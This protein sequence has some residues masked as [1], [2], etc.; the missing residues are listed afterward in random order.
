MKTKNLRPAVFLDRDG[1]LNVD[2][3]YPH[4]I[5]DMAL[6]SGAA[7]AVKAF[8]DA[9]YWT[10]IITNQSGIA[11]GY[12]D[13]AAFERFNQALCVALA[14]QGAHI[15]LILHC[16]H[17]P[18]FTGPCPC[19]KPSPHLINLATERLSV[20][21]PHSLMI[22]DRSSDVACAV[23]VGIDGHL[24]TGGDLHD[25]CTRQRIFQ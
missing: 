16:P 7:K 24:F 1:T 5:E 15:D 21:L 14:E 19:R 18:D 4:R 10:V 11:R 2:C 25:F 22:G 17:H 6:I 13:T 20:D 3:Q 9:D 8:N 23:A 12:F